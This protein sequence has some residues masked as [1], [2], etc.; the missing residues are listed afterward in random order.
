MTPAE[1]VMA[2]HRYRLGRLR[3][4]LAS[5]WARHGEAVLAGIF[6]A[7]AAALYLT[8]S[9]IDERE[10]AA[11]FDRMLAAKN[12]QLVDLRIEQDLRQEACGTAPLFWIIE[13]NSPRLVFDKMTLAVQ[14]MDVARAGQWVPYERPAP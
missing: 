1:R 3:I 6:V 14:A 5:W 2:T 7:A 12:R 9:W 4:V 13:G 10:R 11:S 8:Q